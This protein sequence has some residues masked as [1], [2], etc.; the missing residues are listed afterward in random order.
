MTD[1]KPSYVNPE[2]YNSMLT[3]MRQGYVAMTGEEW[4][5]YFRSNGIMT[6]TQLAEMQAKIKSRIAN[7]ES[8]WWQKLMGQLW[9]RFVLPKTKDLLT[10]RNLLKILSQLDKLLPYMPSDFWKSVL[11]ALD[12]AAEF[13]YDRMDK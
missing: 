3:K 9:Y 10:P 5:R 11:K 12:K 13:A 2:N 1:Y 4:S 8:T 6:R 7:Q